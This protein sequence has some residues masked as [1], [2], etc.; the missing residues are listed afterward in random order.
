VSVKLSHPRAG[1]LKMKKQQKKSSVI[2]NVR[3]FG[4][5][6]ICSLMAVA[7]VAIVIMRDR[8]IEEWR[9]QL[10]NMSLILAEQTSQSVFAAYQTLDAVT[11]RVKQANV[12][13][14]ASFRK[15]L[16]TR[17][18]YEVLHEKVGGLPQL[19]VVSIIAANG[20]NI[21][22]SRSYPV[23]EINLAE[24]DYFKEHR[25]NPKLGDFISQPVRNK[26]NGKWTF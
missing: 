1:I 23:P 4:G 2:R 8:E 26:G 14:H 25:D 5:I 10:G 13:D 15:K 12:T 11:E 7:I 18:M 19:D 9:K 6:V 3:L 22:F 17:E 21:N 20:D 24:R 16:A